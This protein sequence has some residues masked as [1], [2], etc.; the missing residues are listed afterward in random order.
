MQRIVLVEPDSAL[1]EWCRLHLES[2]RLAVLAFDDVLPALEAVRLEPP[3]LFIIAT[4]VHAAGAFA[5]V[6]TIRSSLRTVLT[7]ILFLI[8]N[9]DAEALTYALS[10]EPKGIVTKPLTRAV[11][12]RS[13]DSL[14]RSANRGA[15]G[16][17]TAM[18]AAPQSLDPA[19]G[20]GP[21]APAT[22]LL[23]DARD[24]TVLVVVLRNFVSLARA[25]S[26]KP[27]EELLRGFM[28]GAGDAIAEQGGWIVRADATQ[29]VALFED[30]PKA[31]RSHS[32]RAIESALRVLVAAR[33]AKASAASG[34][35]NVSFPDLSVGCG[36]HSGEVVIARLPGGG[37]L[38]LTIAGQTAELAYR[39]D[40]RAKGLG[41]SIAASE[42]AVG[43][44]A[45]AFLVGRRA[46]LSDSDHG[47]ALFISEI[48][49][50][51]PGFAKPGELPAVAE[52][53]EAVLAN[54]MLAKLAGDVDQFAADKTIMVGVSRK[55]EA[56]P[57]PQLPDRQ[58]GRKIG[59][60]RYVSTYAVVH[61]PT[62]REEVMKMARA[63]DL[64]PGF[65]VSYLEQYR[66]LSKL[67]QRNV[68]DVCDVG[69]NAYG[70]YVVLEHLAG[71]QL[72]EAIRKRMP[73]GRALNC[74]AEMCLALDTIHAIGIVH[75][76]L[77]AEHFLFREDGVLALADFNVT[78]RVSDSIGLA[79]PA[80]SG[81]HRGAEAPNARGGSVARTDF[82][83]VGR[84]FHAML[85]GDVSLLTGFVD[86]PTTDELFGATRLPLALSPLQPCL[87]GLLAIG[88]APPVE[89]GEDVLVELLALKEVFPFDIRQAVGPGGQG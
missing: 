61:L 36:V 67:E 66:K 79:R 64:P 82:R 43:S 47:V 46:S 77:R 78:D 76:A 58:L 53:R 81:V 28:A 74:L 24:T 38:A 87:D 26:A 21:S 14:L 7:P 39:L 63:R 16:R 49:G 86:E 45:G 52:A 41:W 23:L 56:E 3:D 57:P 73:L 75:G 72:L 17:G 60:G 40:G 5:M 48:L 34:Q 32:A 50:F 44:A 37:H 62:A 1:R 13:V 65:L 85:T 69:E 55:S 10:I 31:D 12:L 33:R 88:S 22:G 59:Q 19:R 70:G 84:I 29:L 11:L 4:D 8:P 35:R 9:H 15:T 51:N 89:R 25:M 42:A 2:E 80:E 20:A 83:S 6:A 71:G 68:V 27:L 30:S 18:A 54:T